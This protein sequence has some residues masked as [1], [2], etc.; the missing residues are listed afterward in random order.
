MPFT[1]A[2]QLFTIIF[3]IHFTLIIDRVNR[4]YNP[5][6]TYNAWKGQSHAIKRLLV[7]WIIVYFIPL[8]NFAIYLISLGVYNVIFDPYIRGVINIVL[9][10]LL[11]FFDFGYYRI[12]EAI[13]YAYP[14]EFYTDKEIDTVLEKER[15]EVR[16]HLLPGVAYVVATMVIFLVLILYN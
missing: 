16:A 12:F 11:S 9:V 4:N 2:Q 6:D 15:G 10:A 1:D 3:A 5:Y 7:N 8:I 14:K 13:L